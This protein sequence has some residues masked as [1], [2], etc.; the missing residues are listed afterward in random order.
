MQTTNS[1]GRRCVNVLTGGARNE[2]NFGSFIGAQE[3]PRTR[4]N[5]PSHRWL[6][7]CSTIQLTEVAEMRCKEQVRLEQE[8][9]AVRTEQRRSPS[10]KL[11]READTLDKKVKD[12]RMVHTSGLTTPKCGPYKYER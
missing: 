9:D 6:G 7:H 10:E 12:H 8:L 4:R 1:L 5:T 2:N 11:K 3:C